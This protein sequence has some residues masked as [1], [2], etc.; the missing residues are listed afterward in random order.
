MPYIGNN[1]V[2]Q[3]VNISAQSIDAFL[4]VDTV[5]DAPEIGQVLK[6]NGTN[7]VPD[8]DTGTG[9]GAT[10]SDLQ[11]VTDNGSSTTNVIVAPGFK[12]NA[13]QLNTVS[14]T[15]GDIKKIGG[16][17]YYHDGTSWK[18]FYLFD[19]V[20]DATAVDV[21]WD[22][23]QVRL[24]FEEDTSVTF[25]GGIKSR[26]YVNRLSPHGI[27]HSPALGDDIS[28]V[29]SP[30]KFGTKSLKLRNISKAS[31]LRWTVGREWDPIYNEIYLSLDNWTPE[32]R[33]G[34]ID[35]SGDWT[36][37]FWIY[38]PTNSLSASNIGVGYT[39]G[40]GAGY[41]IFY[42]IDQS[43]PAVS[44]GLIF[45][46]DSFGNRRLWWHNSKTDTQINLI[47][48]G[49]T[50]LVENSWYHI[51]VSRDGSSGRIAGFLDGVSSS[52]G[53]DTSVWDHQ[54]DGYKTSFGKF[55]APATNNVN[56]IDAGAD[57]FIDDLR[58]TQFRRYTYGYNFTA[59]TAAY[60]IAAP[61]PSSIDDDWSDVEFRMTFDTNF[62]DISPNSYT[63]T[64]VDTGVLVSNSTV[65][66]GTG[67]LAVSGNG[68]EGLKVGEDIDTSGSWTFE[69][70][71]NFNSLPQYGGGGYNGHTNSV[72]WS[73][74][75]YNSPP[76]YT[77]NIAFGIE[78]KSTN[79]NVY[80]FWW[81]S[82]LTKTNL[83][84]SN[85]YRGDLLNKWFHIAITRDSVNGAINMYFNGYKVSRDGNSGLYDL[86]T[87]SVPHYSLNKFHIGGKA[88][89]WA[90]ASGFDILPFD[91][92]VDDVRFT[93]SVKYTD[94]FTPPTGPLG[95]T[96][97]VVTPIVQATSGEGILALGSTPTWTG[98]SGWTVQRIVSGV[99]RVDFVGTYNSAIDYRVFTQFM[100]GPT[101]PVNVRISRAAGYM[102]V[103]VTRSDG[104]LAVDTGYVSIR[105]TAA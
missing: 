57:Y 85:F 77:S 60:P 89:N 30:V 59:P 16:L 70:W 95:T 17:P 7:W 18:R 97:T 42:N 79:N 83:G 11:A 10:S 43:T 101:E 6:W 45:D 102:D 35:W 76:D 8:D 19:S 27:T 49:A 9:G 81:Y 20:E 53:I 78:T 82:D 2:S 1:P 88:P 48:I 93:N 32:K 64:T 38:F 94:N 91:G 62:N 3:E 39:T 72:L 4:D 36:V 86:A 13:D 14:G 5:S 52:S 98:T 96:G 29:S 58:I 66:Y 28:L 15:Q 90:F 51:A 24:D 74:G 61:A 104:A 84:V 69:G 40:T 41:G 92:H 22:D 73:N 100:D 37:E 67:S 47:N 103:S 75:Y 99:Y 26:N 63:G 34:C 50:A 65:K 54:T 25:P 55:Y 71:F 105:V 46:I 21:N 23:V 33:G 56:E 12:L 31:E 68:Y 87:S 44:F 80:D